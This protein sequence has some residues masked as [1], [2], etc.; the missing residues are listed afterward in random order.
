MFVDLEIIF[1]N[2]YGYIQFTYE[3]PINLRTKIDIGDIV[4]VPF[5]NVERQ[6]IVLKVHNENI[7]VPNIKSIFKKVGNIDQFQLKYLEQIAIS[8]NTNI[9]ILLHKHIEYSKISNQKKIRTGSSGVYGNKKLSTKL[10]KN[11]NVI[12]TSSLLEAKKVAETLKKEG[13][14]VDFYQKTGGVKEFTNLWQ[15]LKSFQ[16][17]IILSVNFEKIIIKDN[18]N[19]HFFNCNNFSYNLPYLNNI[20]IVESSIIKHKIFKGHFFYYSEFPSLELFNKVNDYFLEI[21]DVSIDNIYGNSLMECVELFDRKY[22]NEPLHIYTANKDINFISTK[23]KLTNNIN[24]DKIEAA[25]MINPTIS[26]NGILS[27]NRLIRLIKNL[28]FFRNKNIKIINF[29]TKKI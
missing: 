10:K 2:T 28:D 16:N 22:N 20:N 3:V 1:N 24:S 7:I 23:H 11:N 25:I 18:L 12:F 17:I 27:S 6:A 29:S 8:N 26:Y 13:K 15:N 21:P 19:F 14:N 5:R 4:T 9:G